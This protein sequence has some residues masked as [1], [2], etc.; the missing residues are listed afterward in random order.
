MAKPFRMNRC[1]VSML[2]FDTEFL[3]SQ[4]LFEAVD[5]KTHALHSLLEL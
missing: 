2:S 4:L 1:Y 3:S 5:C